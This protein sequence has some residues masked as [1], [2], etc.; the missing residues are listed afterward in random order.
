MRSAIAQGG[1]EVA[2]RVQAVRAD[3]GVAVRPR[4]GHPAHLRAVT[5]RLCAGIGPHDPVRDPGQP[6]HLRA[7]Q[8]HEGSWFGR[9]GT[10]HIYGTWSVLTA[11]AQAGIRPEDPAVA[12]A[13]AWLESRQN[14]DGGWGESNDSY[15]DPGL[16]GGPEASTPY[17]TAWAL[18]GL[19]AAGQAQQRRRPPASN[20]VGPARRD[21]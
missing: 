5:R 2:D 17:Q 11:L 13:V 20:N 4:G 18:L 21:R 6:R 16:A 9:W 12:R 10:N 8:E 1:Y 19:L 14:A 15:Q 7:E 3:H